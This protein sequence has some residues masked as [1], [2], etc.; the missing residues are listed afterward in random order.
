M[1]RQHGVYTVEFAIVGL[2]FF[3]LLFAVIEVGRLLFTWHTLDEAARRGARTA[4]VCPVGH[5]APAR[6]AVFS[7]PAGT[8]QSPILPDL[9]TA[10]VSVEYLDPNGGTLA[11]PALNF[12]A[13]RYVRVAIDNYQHQF[14]VP[15]FT[16]TLN[17]PRFETVLPRESLG[18]PREGGAA[19]CFGTGS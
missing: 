17:A 3:V 12:T 4:A 18:I 5:S 8:G 7:T 1:K 10:N 2:L 16:S 14:L 6:V 13:I 9:T 11:S 15:L 19:Q